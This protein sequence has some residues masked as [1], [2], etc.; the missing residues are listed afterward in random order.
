MKRTLAFTCLLATVLTSSTLAPVPLAAQETARTAAVAVQPDAVSFDAGAVYDHLRLTLDGPDHR[1]LELSSDGV[2]GVTL[3]LFDDEGQALPDGLYSYE[4]RGTAE[5][6]KPGGLIRSGF[7][8]IRDG[9]FVSP[10]LQETPGRAPR[11]ATSLVTKDQVVLDDLIVDGSICVGFDCTNGE[12]FGFSTMILKENN[13]RILFN[14]TS[15]SGAF[16]NHDWSLIAND[17]LNGG[18]NRFSIADC[19][20]NPDGC[21]NGDAEFTIVGGAPPNSLFVDARGDIGAGTSTPATKLHL[22]DGNTPTLRLSQDNSSGFA[23]Q[24]WDVG[25]NEVQF[26]VRDVTHGATFPLRIRPGAPTSS[27]DVASS[28]DVGIGT[29]QPTARLDVAGDIAVAGTVDGRDVAGDGSTLDAHVADFD[30][31]HQVTAAQSGA[32]PAGTASSVVAAHEAT[33][34]HTNIPSS[35]PVAIGEG[36]TGATDAATA[37][38][39]LGIEEDAT[40]AG[41]LAAASFS[42]KPAAAT[43]TFSDPYPAGTVYVVVLTAVTSDAKKLESVNLV[44]KDETGFTATL[45]GNGTNLVEVDWVARPVGE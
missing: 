12:N 1:V 36:G 9:S 11:A 10:E 5:E 7:V 45:G 31:P 25:A 40:K 26:Y 42:G 4:L 6:G 43:V 23:P 17:S 21:G 20:Q 19:T 16:P 28:G 38:S 44:A 33:F 41:I 3:G 32:D 13:T 8:S 27:I 2:A 37:R 30:N 34:D 22:L 24:T 29:D 39:N 18:A 35:L 15:S 14:D